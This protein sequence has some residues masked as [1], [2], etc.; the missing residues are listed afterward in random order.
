M[1][2]YLFE[3]DEY[4]YYAS[5]LI[6]GEDSPKTLSFKYLTKEPFR[7][8]DLSIS[9]LLVP[10]E[11]GKSSDTKRKV[12]VNSKIHIVASHAAIMSGISTVVTLIFM[13]DA[14]N[15]AIEVSDV[16]FKD[17]EFTS[18]SEKWDEYSSSK[19]KYLSVLIKA[20]C[21]GSPFDLPRCLSDFPNIAMAVF[22]RLFSKNQIPA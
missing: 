21:D 6:F 18:F 7:T 15:Q 5:Y 17:R 9:K 1:T 20:L 11:Y 16:L 12:I 4:C 3:K 10:E 2:D 14:L 22:E 19:I 13:D 8:V